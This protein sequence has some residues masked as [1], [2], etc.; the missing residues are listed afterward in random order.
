LWVCAEYLNFPFDPE[1]Q[2]LIGGGNNYTTINHCPHCMSV[3]FNSILDILII[4]I[5]INKFDIRLINILKKSLKPLERN[6]RK[7]YKDY[8][9]EAIYNEELC[10]EKNIDKCYS[11]LSTYLLKLLT[12]F[13]TLTS[14]VQS[15]SS[16]T[17]SSSMSINPNN[18]FLLINRKKNIYNYVLTP[19]PFSL[20]SDSN[21]MNIDRTSLFLPILPFRKLLILLEKVLLNTL[22]EERGYTTMLSNLNYYRFSS[23][24]QQTLM[25]KEI[26]NMRDIF[27]VAPDQID[28]Y[29]YEIIVGIE[30]WKFRRECVI[31]INPKILI[32]SD[33]NGNNFQIHLPGV[34]IG[35]KD[36]KLKKSLL[37][38]GG[39]YTIGHIC[40]QLNKHTY[41]KNR[42]YELYWKGKKLEDKEFL[43]SLI[44]ILQ[45]DRVYDGLFL[46]FLD[47]KTSF[48]T[49]T[50]DLNN[51]NNNNMN[52]K[53]KMKN[54][55][56]KERN[57]Y[58]SLYTL[59]S[60]LNNKNMMMDI[61]STQMINEEI[62]ISSI[63]DLDIYIYERNINTTNKY[64]S[65]MYDIII[66]QCITLLLL[67]IIIFYK[68]YII[69]IF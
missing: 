11:L 51:N 53:E 22:T 45:D 18:P 46:V 26:I 42:R 36:E 12:H 58:T 31:E 38:V 50:L 13:I 49:Y 52:E 64:T 60:K 40:K 69:I 2:K 3:I 30:R 57:I 44:G 66:L 32:L 37:C 1:R 24:P 35:M 61:N 6:R 27:V 33:N 63:S 21:N 15:S 28:K 16:S 34:Y 67:N 9:G 14:S 5:E 65:L 56:R 29:E 17:S 68:Y 20:S 10:E 62:K 59:M 41:F 8:N 25:G 19:S 7:M 54:V 48:Y 4:F 47:K 39:L 43:M 55:G 23:L